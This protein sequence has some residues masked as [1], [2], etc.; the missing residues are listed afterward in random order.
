MKTKEQ[1]EKENNYTFKVLTNV[2]NELLNTQKMI[3]DFH[4]SYLEN[5][6][7]KI[8]IRL[9]TNPQGE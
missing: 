4:K 5:E 1:I 7:T 9:S 8:D 6:K 2:W 3:I